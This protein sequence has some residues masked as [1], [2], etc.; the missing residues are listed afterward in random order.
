LFFD[1]IFPERF[2]LLMHD[3]HTA[4]EVVGVFCLATFSRDRPRQLAN[5]FRNN[6]I[7]EGVIALEVGPPTGTDIYVWRA[8]LKSFHPFSGIHLKL[9]P[10]TTNEFDRWISSIDH[11]M[12]G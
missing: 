5:L 12:Q 7:G 1:G 11:P 8:V 3:M 4:Q 9:T 2:V 6:L 10:S